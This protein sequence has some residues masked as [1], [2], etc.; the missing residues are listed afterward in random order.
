M[1]PTIVGL[2][3][4]TILASTLLDTLTS[5]WWLAAAALLG[6]G[7]LLY[8]RACS[9]EAARQRRLALTLHE[10]EVARERLRRRQ[11]RLLRQRPAPDVVVASTPNSVIWFASGERRLPGEQPL[12]LARHLDKLVLRAEQ[13]GTI[14]RQEA[15]SQSLLF[16]IE[17]LHVHLAGLAHEVQPKDLRERVGKEA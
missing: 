8:R 9:D 4:L 10:I 12:R 16:E 5:T 3:C 1:M 11:E 17:R 6:A 7:W 15:V 13:I 14:A 2:D